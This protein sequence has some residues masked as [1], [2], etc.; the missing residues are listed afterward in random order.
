MDFLPREKWREGAVR[1][2]RNKGK[3]IHPL[4]KLV[5]KKEE[6]TQRCCRGKMK[7][8]N[9]VGEGSTGGPCDTSCHKSLFP[10]L[11]VHYGQ[12]REPPESPYTILFKEPG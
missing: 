1:Q 5:L 8:G 12:Q 9:G 3:D 2:Q 7:T 4:A 6:K 11:C 10:G